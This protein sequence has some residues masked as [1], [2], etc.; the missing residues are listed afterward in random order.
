MDQP[1]AWILRED[2]TIPL[3]SPLDGTIIKLNRHFMRTTVRATQEKDDYIF[4]MEGDQLCNKLQQFCGDISGLKYFTEN[5]SL[6]RKFLE[7]TYHQPCMSDLGATLT[8]GGETQLCL[9]KVI[10]ESNF[11]RL[12]TRLFFVKN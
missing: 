3:L 12:I 11:K 4:K 9:Q 1:I 7:N 8:D 2:K 10:G 5:V 6:V